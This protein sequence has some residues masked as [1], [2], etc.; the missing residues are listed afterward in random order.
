MTYSFEMKLALSYPCEILVSGRKPVQVV[1]SLEPHK[2]LMVGPCLF[3][4]SV[5]WFTYEANI[6]VY[7]RFSDCATGK[8]H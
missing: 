3:S 6:L 5:F 1:G 2:G 7:Q 4:F 8:L